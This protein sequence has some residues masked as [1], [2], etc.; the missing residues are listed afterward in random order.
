MACRCAG[1][2]RSM[3]AKRGDGWAGEPLCQLKVACLCK[4]VQEHSHTEA[5]DE[6]SQKE[7]FV[8]VV[9][10]S[11]RLANEIYYTKYPKSDCEDNQSNFKIVH[12]YLRYA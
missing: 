10:K 8:A 3:C 2:A 9:I 11:I 5:R 7:S 6:T 12:G 1:R 4:Q